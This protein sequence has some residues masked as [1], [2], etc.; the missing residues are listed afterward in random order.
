MPYLFSRRSLSRLETCHPDLILLMREVIASPDCPCDVT[1]LCGYRGQEEQDQAFASG[2]SKLRYPQSR[3]NRI[4]SLACDVAPF[5]AGA[6]SWSWP[7]YYPLADHIKATWTRLQAEGRLSD[8]YRISWGGDFSTWK[9]GPH[10]EL[11][12]L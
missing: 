5:I 4:P 3:H 11:R 1:V 8:D 9:D 10:W 2:N 12:G 7:D 6:V